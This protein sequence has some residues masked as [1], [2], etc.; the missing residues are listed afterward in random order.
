MWRG[1]SRFL[2]SISTS[3]P[4]FP[5]NSVVALLI[6]ERSLEFYSQGCE[7]WSQKRGGILHKDEIVLI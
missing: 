1:G 7:K 5:V 3:P 4:R 6:M 2:T